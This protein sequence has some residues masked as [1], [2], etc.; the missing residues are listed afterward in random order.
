MHA[1]WWSIPGPVQVPTIALRC[2]AEEAAVVLGAMRRTKVRTAR[3]WIPTLGVLL[4]GR[5]ALLINDVIA[6]LRTLHLTVGSVQAPIEWLRLCPVCQEG[7]NNGSTSCG[8]WEAVN[9][10]A[11]DKALAWGAP[12]IGF[13]DPPPG[14]A[15]NP[16]ASAPPPNSRPADPPRFESIPIDELLAGF[17]RRQAEARARARAEG[18]GEDDDLRA[19]LRELF[20]QKL[21][22]ASAVPVKVQE[23]AR[24]LGVSETTYTL[25]D[26]RA[27]FARRAHETHP[28]KA[29][30]SPEAFRRACA[31][32]DVLLEWR[33]AA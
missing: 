2:T 27:A 13:A 24:E 6:E 20:N 23:A 21:R 26:V 9:R 18:R 28:D 31:A 29:G 17:R 15:S 3:K 1:T 5:T 32:R 14:V 8:A 4:L 12:R 30:G 25:A 10:A 19:K 16:G 22:E 11:H 33:G 7:L